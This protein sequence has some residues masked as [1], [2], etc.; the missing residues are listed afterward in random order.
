MPDSTSDTAGGDGLA[1]GVA[2]RDEPELARVGCLLLA[3]EIDRHIEDLREVGH[4]LCRKAFDG[5]DVTPDD[6]EALENGIARLECALEDHAKPVA[7]DDSAEP[8]ED[9][10]RAPVRDHLMDVADVLDETADDDAVS[11]A[12]M[13][14]EELSLFERTVLGDGQDTDDS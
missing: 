5:E 6:I 12:E 7:Y 10:V 1:F 11:T 2:D 3:H 9:D 14:R 8:D 13:V 4:E